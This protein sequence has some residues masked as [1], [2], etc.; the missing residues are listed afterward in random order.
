M[1]QISAVYFWI[2]SG[3]FK[4][5]F[6]RGPISDVLGNLRFEHLLKASYGSIDILSKIDVLE[7]FCQKEEALR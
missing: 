2:P 5:L 6:A 1:L 3:S 4:S 7:V